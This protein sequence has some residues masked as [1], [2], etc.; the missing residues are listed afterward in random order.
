MLAACS[1]GCCPTRYSLGQ[2]HH[3]KVVS[4]RQHRKNW[5]RS[6][7]SLGVICIK[8]YKTK[9]RQ[10][11]FK[12]KDV[13]I[14]FLTWICCWSKLILCCCCRSCCCCLAICGETENTDNTV[15][16]GVGKTNLLPIN[17]GSDADW[18]KYHSTPLCRELNCQQVTLKEDQKSHFISVTT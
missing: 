2:S 13:E 16:L 7:S 9:K 8:S 12:W 4:H 17:I 18:C 14:L 15:R 5:D 1:D 10:S 3:L 6:P 11:R